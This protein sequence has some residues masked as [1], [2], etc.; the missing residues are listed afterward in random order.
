[1]VP[2]MHAPKIVSNKTSFSLLIMSSGLISSSY[3]QHL[4]TELTRFNVS[5]VSIADI[6]P[7]TIESSSNLLFLGFESEWVG[8]IASARLKIN[9]L[10]EIDNITILFAIVNYRDNQICT[11]S[12]LIQDY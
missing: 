9:S 8:D 5:I 2:M 6:D 11:Q 12:L 10:R 1:M 3:G 7:S 4:I